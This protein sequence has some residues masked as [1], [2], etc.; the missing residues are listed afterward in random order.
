[1]YLLGTVSESQGS[2]S[3]LPIHNTVTLLFQ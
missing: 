1:V 2:A 3:Q